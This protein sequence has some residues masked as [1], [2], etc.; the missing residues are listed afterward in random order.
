MRTIFLAPKSLRAENAGLRERNAD[1]VAQLAEAKSSTLMTPAQLQAI[2]TMRAEHAEMTAEQRKI[3]LFLRDN[4]R[5]EIER[6]EHAGMS[7]SEVLIKYLARV[8][9]GGAE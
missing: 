7:L 2:A 9:H 3:A 6:G 5:A 1:L 4:F 8:K